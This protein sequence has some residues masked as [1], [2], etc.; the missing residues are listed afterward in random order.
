MRRLAPRVWML[1]RSELHIHDEH[2]DRKL[3][4]ALRSCVLLF[5]SVHRSDSGIRCL[6]V[7]PLGNFG[8]R[9]GFGGEPVRLVPTRPRLMVSALRR[10][11]ELGAPA[12]LSVVYEA[13]HHGPVLGQPAFFVEIAESVPA[14]TRDRLVRPLAA[15][16]VD[17]TENAADRVVVGI[18]GGHYAPHFSE[19]ALRR[20]WAFGHIV[21]RHALAG[22][23]P[24]LEAQVWEGTPGAEGFLFQRATDLSRGGW[25][26]LGPRMSEGDAP[27][28]NG[29]RGENG[30][31][32]R[33]R[34]DASPVSGT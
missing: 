5:P 24:E 23:T 31:S 15:A 17:L 4:E 6:T 14:E 27:A 3:P 10:L 22:L 1:R 32:I 7:H 26:K 19:V 34:R 29:A 13:T 30:G 16:I 18:G 21:P 25:L 33:S 8:V 2:L 9:P 20:H 12:G 11:H 28:L